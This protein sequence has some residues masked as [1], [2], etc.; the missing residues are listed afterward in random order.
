MDA[1]RRGFYH[2]AVLEAPF[3]IIRSGTIPL[4]LQVLRG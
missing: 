3:S 4:L 1:K 2:F